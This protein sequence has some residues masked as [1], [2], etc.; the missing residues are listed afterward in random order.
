MLSP[1][2]STRMDPTRRVE[3]FLRASVPFDARARQLVVLG[4]VEALQARGLVDEIR[5]DTWAHRITDAP[6]EATLA[7][8]ALDR[9][10]HWALA[11]QATLS[12]GFDTHECHSGFTGQR[13]DTTVLPVVCLAVYDD[14]ELVAVYPHSTGAGCVSVA[15]GLAMLEA[16]AGEVPDVRPSSDRN[17]PSA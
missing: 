5:V 11:H 7:L 15:D 10:E 16:D 6:P 2:V 3:V 4:R 13:F 1:G 14:D 17:L 9:F 12:P 8:S